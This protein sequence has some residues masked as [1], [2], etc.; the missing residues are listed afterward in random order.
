MVRHY[1][2]NHAV[3][4]D[5]DLVFPTSTGHWQTVENWRKRGFY[6]ACFE[7]GLVRKAAVGAL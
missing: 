5:H 1:A 6:E 3:A 7:A 2:K 4:N